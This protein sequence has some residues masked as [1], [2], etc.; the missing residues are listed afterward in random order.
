VL[1]QSLTARQDPS[2]QNICALRCIV[3]VDELFSRVGKELD[4]TEVE[5]ER[6]DPSENHV[7][8]NFSNAF[9]PEAEVV[10]T[11]NWR[12]DEE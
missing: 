12:V 4:L 6:V 1:D 5:V 10:G 7:R 11:D 8:E 3:V 2:V 9:F